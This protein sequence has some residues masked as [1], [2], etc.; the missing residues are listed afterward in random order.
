MCSL[1]ESNIQLCR[2]VQMFA[3]VL[4]IG[5]HFQHFLT[6]EYWPML[7]YVPRE[8]SVTIWVTMNVFKIFNWPHWLI[9]RLFSPRSACYLSKHLWKMCLRGTSLVC[10]VSSWHCNTRHTQKCWL[11]CLK[12][13][14]ASKQ[15]AG[16]GF[17]RIKVK[18]CCFSSPSKVGRSYKD[19]WLTCWTSSPP[20][21]NRASLTAVCLGEQPVLLSAGFQH[22]ILDCGVSYFQNRL[23]A[24]SLCNTFLYKQQYPLS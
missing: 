13:L 9:R 5:K 7:K 8:Q 2:T 3:L 6:V 20:I 19:T 16:N 23:G 11:K 10:L 4:L 22:I 1:I 14:W 17:Q 15:E 21:M 18:F 24:V 12:L